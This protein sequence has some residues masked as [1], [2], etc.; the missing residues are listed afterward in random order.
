LA[1][2]LSPSTLRGSAAAT[3]LPATGGKSPAR[4]GT[5]TGEAAASAASPTA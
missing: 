3:A 2:R 1:F 4:C 5:A